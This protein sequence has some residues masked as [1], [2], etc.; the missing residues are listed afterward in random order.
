MHYITYN[1][2]AETVHCITTIR[3]DHSKAWL[4][5]FHSQL[6]RVVLTALVQAFPRDYCGKINLLKRLDMKWWNGAL[7]GYT[8]PSLSALSGNLESRVLSGFLL[9]P[10]CHEITLLAHESAVSSREWT[11]RLRVCTLGALFSLARAGNALSLMAIGQSRRLVLTLSVSA[12][13]VRQN[14]IHLTNMQA[15][16]KQNTSIISWGWELR[17]RDF[18]TA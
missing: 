17:M 13:S 3:E 14:T 11:C 4:F 12:A 7:I 9:A 18:P 5:T 10:N 16:F 8:S 1:G 6:A 2:P 15:L